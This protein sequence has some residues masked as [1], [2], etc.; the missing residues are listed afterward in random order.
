MLN[1]FYD[2]VDCASAKYQS[3]TLPLPILKG[4]PTLTITLRKKK[5]VYDL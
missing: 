3:L 1:Q 4:Y 2:Q 5:D